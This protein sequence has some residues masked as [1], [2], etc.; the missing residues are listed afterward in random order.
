VSINK[1]L[2]IDQI[3]IVHGITGYEA[4]EQMLQ[5]LLGKQFGL[6]FDFITESHDKEKNEAWVKQYFVP[7]ITARLSK[8]ATFCTLVHF[9]IYEKF[10]AGNE[11]YAVIFEND[12]CFLGDFN[13]EIVPIVK[14]A[15]TLPQG[16]IVSLENSTLR[17]P[18][19]RVT[20]RN[21]H[22]YEA[23]QGRCA[24]AYLIDRKAAQNM[25]NEL[26]IN[27]C[28]KVIDW[29]H[30]E[31]VD[32]KIVKMYWAHP[33]ITEQGSFNGKLPSSIS[34]RAD[35]HVRRWKWLLQKFYKMY[36]IRWFK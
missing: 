24:G 10:L 12:V 9:L 6:D 11:R 34:T 35:G 29:W 23:Q 33:A 8:G 32:R 15:D 22:L 7:D 20:K 36:V 19:W 13:K 28:A 31:L 25:L 18:S 27:K 4:R 2:G 16:F 17:F 26:A 21:K 14:E 1:Q 3:Y 5:D 30:N